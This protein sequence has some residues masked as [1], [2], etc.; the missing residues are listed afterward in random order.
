MILLAESADFF[1]WFE[2]AW[3][4]LY[5]NRLYG[6]SLLIIFGLLGGKLISVIKFPKVTGY[7][8]IGILIGPSVLKFLSLEM[9]ESFTIIRQVAIGFIGYT[10]GLEL[11]FNK[12]KKTGKQVTIITLA[13]AFTTAI[14]VCMS[15]VLF[16][17]LIN[18]E[19]AWTYGLILGAIATATAPAPILA[20]VKN[21]RTKGPVT[22]VLLPLVALDDAIGIMLFAIL[23]SFGT[24]LLVANESVS[25]LNI[26]LEPLI[27][28][29]LSVGIGL[30]IG[31]II[32]TIVK[33][34]NREDDKFLMMVIVGFIFFG[35]GIGQAV[36]ASAILLPMTI[37][38]YITNSIEE[39]YKDRLTNTT[40]LFSGPILLSFFTIA[41]AELQLGLL[42]KIG[43]I[44]IIYLIVRVVGKY[45]GSTVSAKMV[46]APKMVQKWI[47][48]TL[49]PQ[50]G[51]AIDMALTTQ[52]RFEA[53]PELAPYM[54]IGLS[55]TTVILAATVIYEVVGLVIVK[56]ALDK[57]GEIDAAVTDWQ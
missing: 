13:Q 6:V 8:L 12:L 51:V 5:E 40:D 10:I 15:I 49:I 28:I 14:L 11:K 19:H 26:L 39:K 29:V 46:K 24:S 52:L 32:T 22:D 57:A 47:G 53:T 42:T 33:R 34:F 35:I 20:V 36:H 2:V 45:V 9:V 48:L 4:H 27:E 56:T 50:A 25:L 38:I 3:E 23:L 54:Q 37:G 55:I 16:L 31:L 7:I 21:Y 1:E 18:A 43:E 17:T 30:L 44:G 41:G